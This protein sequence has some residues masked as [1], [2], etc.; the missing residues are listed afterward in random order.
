MPA[1]DCTQN[2]ALND[3]DMS[4]D[5]ALVDSGIGASGL[6]IYIEKTGETYHALVKDTAVL[7]TLIDCG[8]TF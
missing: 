6:N 4:L 5:A 7:G 3:F 8:R 2:T 1:I